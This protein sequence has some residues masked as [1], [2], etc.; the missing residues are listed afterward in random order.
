MCMRMR[1]GEMEACGRREQR[2][3]E[4]LIK[5]HVRMRREF[6]RIYD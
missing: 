1:E 4:K 5:G 2:R 6:M 3:E